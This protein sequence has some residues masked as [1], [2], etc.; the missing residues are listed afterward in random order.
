MDDYLPRF[1]VKPKNLTKF[2]QTLKSVPATDIQEKEFVMFKRISG[3]LL[4]VMISAVV[5]VG[6]A[7]AQGVTNLGK[8][9]V[10]A[11]TSD[12]ME[13][14]V[15]VDY[16]AIV[17]FQR[18]YASISD[19]DYITDMSRVQVCQ[20][21]GQHPP[22]S[23][24]TSNYPAS[25]G[26][27][28]ASGAQWAGNGCGSGPLSSLF[29]SFL[30]KDLSGGTYS[31]DLNKPV[32]YNPSIDFTSIC[33]DHDRNYTS[34]GTK[35]FADS[36][37]KRQLESLCNA[38]LSDGASCMSFKGKYVSVVKNMGG[39]A[40]ADDQKQLACSAWGAS[41]KKSGCV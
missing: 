21:L 15:P 41:M 12:Y 33:S 16:M 2:G 39:S 8:V 40:C 23:C 35:E 17:R 11:T 34:G 9:V 38:A 19:T 5:F 20:V 25:P 4:T 22:Q 32:K 26:I 13:V 36:R 37:F 7:N 28:S 3:S 31:G 27:P 14:Y 10:T 18:D 1:V 24:T 29:A 6:I 30:L